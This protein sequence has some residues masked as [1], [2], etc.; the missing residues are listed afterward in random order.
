[1]R[2]A[3]QVGSGVDPVTMKTVIVII[4]VGLILVSAIWILTQL[5]DAY[6][7][8]ELTSGEIVRAGVQLLIIVS[9]TLYV[10]M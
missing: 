5:A 2:Q 1:M 9:L 3:F 8:E 7:H 6:S 4:A 10:V